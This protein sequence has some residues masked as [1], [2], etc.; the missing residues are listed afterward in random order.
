MDEQ[1]A[2]RD[3]GMPKMYEELASWWPLLSAPEEYVEEAAIYERLLLEACERPPR[4]LLELGSG[5]G[6]NASHLKRRF[7]ATLVDPSPGMLAHSR[8]L[9]PECEHLE[10]D[11]RT[12]RLGRRFDC[13]FVHDAV[14]YMTSEAELRQAV[15]TAFAHCMPGGAALFAPDHVRE[16]FRPGTDCGGHDG[17]GRGLRYLE[18]SWDPDPEDDT[19][20]ADYAYL[21]RDADGSVRV[22]HDRHTE[23]LFSR[24]VWLRL[25]G[26][27][28]FRARSVPVEHSELE[29]GTYEVFVAVRP[30][31]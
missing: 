26:E 11:M 22:V 8:R 30:A 16:S 19:C 7:R 12:V 21:L 6:N 15:E 29:P 27:A 23:G 4:T 24:A 10:G 13:V 28:G 2:S 1:S 14:V 20:V 31:P 3:G 25:L 17:A 5:G 18:W 9:N